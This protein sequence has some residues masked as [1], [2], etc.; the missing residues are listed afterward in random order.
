[1][2]D[3]CWLKLGK[4]KPYIDGFRVE[5]VTTTLAF[6]WTHAREVASYGGDDTNKNVINGIQI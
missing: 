3:M 6:A 5:R 4:H 2:G 1:M